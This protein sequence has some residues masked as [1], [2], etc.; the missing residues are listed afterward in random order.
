MRVEV[1]VRARMPRREGLFWTDQGRSEEGTRPDTESTL[2]RWRAHVCDRVDFRRCRHT[3][4]WSPGRCSTVCG[5]LLKRAS[6]QILDIFGR[7][8]VRLLAS[9]LAL[10]N[11]LGNTGLQMLL[12]RGKSI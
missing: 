2:W 7:K 8:P 9:S 12:P 4:W 6:S 5:H 1:V 3:G 10:A 11:E